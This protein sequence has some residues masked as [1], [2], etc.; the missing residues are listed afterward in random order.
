MAIGTALAAAALLGV[1]FVLQQQ[2]AQTVPMSDTLS[3]RLLRDLIGRR[4]WLA[5]IA[6]MVA[7]QILG[8]VALGAATITVIEPLLTTN[9]LFALVLARLLSNQRLRLYE[10]WGALA[11]AAGVALFVVVAD[12][13]SGSRTAEYPRWLFIGG[14]I[15][16]AAIAVAVARRFLDARRAVGLALGAG[17]LY[18][19]QDGF[20]RRTL[21]ST[22]S[23]LLTLLRSWPPYAVVTVAI[24]GLVLAQSAFEA[25]PLRLSLPVIAVT[26]P[27][28]GIAYGL[29]VSGD[30]IRTSAL[31]LG[32]EMGALGVAV[33]GCVL[34]TR[35]P[36]LAKP[37][38]PA[39]SSAG[40]SSDSSS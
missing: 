6:A 12:P 8:A 34:V 5:G 2:V 11:L 10:W 16:L 22:G 28:I 20:T 14:T 35:S 31:W 26:E 19:L 21:L 37:D 38:P 4:R 13:R 15:A 1:G 23:G 29:V 32:L 25:A 27:A 30:R 9:V 39:G 24:I 33:I 17:A 18:G 36:V 40:P 3:W 7:G